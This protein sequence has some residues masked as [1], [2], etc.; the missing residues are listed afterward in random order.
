M[1]RQGRVGKSKNYQVNTARKNSVIKPKQG[2]KL[3]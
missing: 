2:V 1:D 3:E